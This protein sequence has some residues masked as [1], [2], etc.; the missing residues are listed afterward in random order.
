[1]FTQKELNLRQR[2]WLEVLNDYGMNVLSGKVSV[3]VNDLNKLLMG[4]VEHFEV[5]SLIF[6]HI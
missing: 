4:S 3:V 1:M 2:R 5:M 6:G